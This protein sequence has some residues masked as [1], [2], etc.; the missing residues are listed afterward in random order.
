MGNHDQALWN[1]I[2]GKPLVMTTMQEVTSRWGLHFEPTL[3]L[4]TPVYAVFR[5]PQTL[6]ILQSIIVTAGAIPIFFLARQELQSDLAGY[7]YSLVYLLFPAL[8]GA[9]LFDFHAAALAAALLSFALWFLANR[10]YRL[11]FVMLLLAM[12]CREDISLI[13][14]LMG[15]YIWLVQRQRSWAVT[16][17]GTG[18][19]WFCLANLVLIPIFSPVGDNIH[20]TRY[21]QW[22]DSMGQVIVNLLTHPLEA[23]TFVFS[24]DRLRYLLRLTMPVAFTA[25]LDPLTLLMTLPVLAINTLSDWPPNYQ[26]DRFH[27]SAI[28]VPFVVVASVNGVTRLVK[29]AAPKFKHVKPRFLQNSLLAMIFIVILAYHVQF[30]HTPIGQYF[31]WPLVTEHHR[32]VDAILSQI[33]P[34]AVVAAQNNLVP[35]IS[36]RE[37]I[38]I[39]PKLSQADQQA[40]Y[41]VVDMQSPLFPYD[42]IENYCAD[43]AKFLATPEYGLIVADDGLLLFK[44]NAPDTATFTPMS[45]CR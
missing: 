18:F 25:L 40:E 24:G 33:P 34:Q 6:I 13:V 17:M 5:V 16:I 26:L 3:L 42:H 37:W 4:L 29:F 27:Y 12:G 30:G 7:I 35:R 41:I 28:I 22:G 43:I 19:L 23:M 14:L 45:P 15:G 44:R 38:F 31:E 8:E 1:T 11:L 21:G 9:L 36:Q 39:L 32:K 20:I 10:Q 2:R